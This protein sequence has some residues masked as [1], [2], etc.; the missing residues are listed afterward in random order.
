M[1]SNDT[2]R[3]F[4]ST[5]YAALEAR[6]SRSLTT[7]L[8]RQKRIFSLVVL[9]VVSLGALAFSTIGRQEDPTIT[10]LFANV[11]T[12]LPGADPARVEAL[13]TEVIE[14]ELQTIPEIK[15][16]KS[17]SSTGVSSVQIALSEFIPESRL[18][19]VWSEIR[20]ALSDAAVLLPP[21]ASAPE[22]DN[23]R[24]D[25]FTAIFALEPTQN[26]ERDIPLSVMTRYAERFQDMLRANA[27]AA[28]V[29]LYGE[30]R[31]EILVEVDQTRL[32]FLGLTPDQV[33]AAI[34]AADAKVRAGRVR[35]ASVDYLLE[36][37][38][39]IRDLE[40]I[41]AIPIITGATGVEGAPITRLGDVASVS[42][43]VRQPAEE[44]AYAE[45]ER[46]ILIAARM[47]PKLQVDAWMER[48]QRLAEA[49]R[50]ELP[51]GLTLRQTFDQSAYTFERLSDLAINMLIGV[52]LVVAV[53][54]VTLGWRA[55]LI[56]ALILPLTS[57]LSIF[58]LQ[59]VG[60]VIH[61]MSVTGLIVALGLLVDG[62]IVMTDE[63]RRRLQKGMPRLAAI[64]LAVRRLA[65]PLLAST[66]TTVLAFMP[67]ALLPGPA[68][69]FVGSIAIAVIVML[70]SSLFLALTVT[71]ALA[72]FILRDGGADRRVEDG[73][74]WNAYR[75]L[76]KLS[77]RWRV[78]AAAIAA[79]PAILG[80][81]AAPTLVSQFFPETDRNQFH[82]QIYLPRGAAIDATETAA[83]KVD[84]TLRA[85]PDVRFVQWVIGGSAPGFYY[86]LIPQ[87]DRQPEFAQAL[88]TT[89]SPEATERLVPA[90]QAELD[91]SVPEARV[92]VRGLIQGPPVDAP[93]EMRI[94][95][96]DLRVLT[97]L[98][99]EATA[100]MAATPGVT[101]AWASFSGGAPKLTLSLDEDKVRLAGL[102]LGAVARQLE[103][104]IEGVEGGSLL[105]GSEQLPVRVRI[106]AED[107]AAADRIAALR[108]LPNDAAARA[109][110]G[111][112]P[113]VPLSALGAFT[114]EPAQSQINRFDGERANTIRG[115]LQLGVL[116]EAA[117]NVFRRDLA[118]NP[119]ALP[120]GYAF[121]WGGDSDARDETVTN[122]MSSVSLVMALTI[123]TI[124][125]TF[126]SWRL[127]A[128]AG[129]VAILSAGLSMLA[130][131]VFQYPFGIQALIGVIGSIGVSINA[132]I[133]IMTGLQQDPAA[134]RGEP[135]AIANVVMGSTR[136]I[137][138][139]TLTTFGGFLPLILG[140]GGFWPPFA[141]AVAGGVLLS[142]IVSLFF[143]PPIYSL[144]VGRPKAAPAK[145]T[146][147]QTSE[148]AAQPA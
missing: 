35:G 104:L 134:A 73:P 70:G 137:V 84:E 14:A 141:M 41:R 7:L 145:T 32:S 67:M 95:G 112:D 79:S 59:L 116:P 66:A 144:L 125:L 132:A 20:D 47:T 148:A 111:A 96:P 3:E 99:E 136:H 38:G 115:F 64:G 28:L 94:T 129:V 88:V 29:Q 56:V 33:S 27:N 54:L 9:M 78:L 49:F 127:S 83:L 119:I 82:V 140:G 92:L 146:Q 4:A 123:A 89:A 23:D 103:T 93:I 53:L 124:L 34:T 117:L 10:N 69:D 75:W 138:S 108:V 5:D 62:A 57:L 113:G 6:E 72:G 86:N 40:R 65:V 30:G 60:V 81:L 114:L 1:S 52:G 102:T 91:E 110:Q 37:E 51:D 43:S 131:A 31:E 71:P 63:I 87:N 105:E 97:A 50:A 76:L 18:E 77:L 26:G 133:I 42:R 25:A 39:E 142:T 22:F 121:E 13:V 118:E 61:Q 126:N 80:F 122:L 135:D 109:A 2:P 19:Q 21:E 15:E 85:A 74:L 12:V 68:G 106:A 139:T 98:G 143:T 36:I 128:V 120:P 48:V 11:L 16:L 101:H 17:T 24:A 90:L 45:G 55:A 46:A 44:I 58:I 130:L 107:R 147:P 8:Y 100:R